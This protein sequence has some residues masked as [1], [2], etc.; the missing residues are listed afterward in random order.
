MRMSRVGGSADTFGGVCRGANGATTALREYGKPC[1]SSARCSAGRKALEPGGVGPRLEAAVMH[2]VDD[3]GLHHTGYHGGTVPF[4]RRHR[5]SSET[6]WSGFHV[7]GST[8]L[9]NYPPAMVHIVS[10][11]LCSHGRNRCASRR[12]YAC[13]TS[14]RRRFLF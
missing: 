11:S 9:V 14:A 3:H 2:G 6:H 5:R 4:F 12:L 10:A 1:L 7:G 8:L 13:G